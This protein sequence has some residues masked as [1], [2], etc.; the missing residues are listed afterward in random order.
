MPPKVGKQAEKPTAGRPERAAE[1]IASEVGRNRRS[2]ARLLGRN[3]RST[4]QGGG[5][6]KPSTAP[7]ITL[8][9]Q[10]M[11]GIWMEHLARWCYYFEPAMLEDFQ[12]LIHGRGP[13]PGQMEYLKT[14]KNTGD[15]LRNF[16]RLFIPSPMRSPLSSNRW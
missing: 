8:S 16:F 5:S 2:D 3:L 15:D 13:T 7:V 10:A 9:E 14:L 4:T 12:R 6:A 11:A 1:P